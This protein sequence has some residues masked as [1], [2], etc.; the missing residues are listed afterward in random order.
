MMLPYEDIDKLV[1][2]VEQF[3][4][5]EPEKAFQ[6]FVGWGK[7]NILAAVAFNIAWDYLYNKHL[8]ANPMHMTRP[9]SPRDFTMPSLN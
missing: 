7:G 8:Q 3:F 9:M 5:K 1:T 4:P 2:A 6:E